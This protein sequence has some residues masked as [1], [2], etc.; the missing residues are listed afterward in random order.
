VASIKKVK[1]TKVAS[2]K[3]AEKKKSSE[4]LPQGGSEIKL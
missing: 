1:A 3:P 4:N 2:Q